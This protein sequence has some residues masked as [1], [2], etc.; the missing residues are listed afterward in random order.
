MQYQQQ[1]RP[2]I[3]NMPGGHIGMDSQSLLGA[4]GGGDKQVHFDWDQ[5][6]AVFGSHGASAMP[7]EDVM[8]LNWEQGHEHEGEAPDI[9]I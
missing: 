9:E 8:D 6:D 1:H 5:W 7:F 4:A 2:S 3:N